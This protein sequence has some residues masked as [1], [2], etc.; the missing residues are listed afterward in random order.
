MVSLLTIPLI[1]YFWIQ[2]RNQKIAT[3]NQLRQ[4]RAIAL[5][6]ADTSLRQKINYASQFARQKVIGDRDI[7]YTTETDLL[8]QNIDNADKIDREWQRRLQ[9]DS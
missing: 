9:S 5:E 3:R 4:Q 1:R 7:T 8:D 2:G 6:N